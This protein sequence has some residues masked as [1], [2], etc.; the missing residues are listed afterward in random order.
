M[1]ETKK[2]EIPENAQPGD[3]PA[4]N[5][6]R[7]TTRLSKELVKMYPQQKTVFYLPFLTDDDALKTR[8]G[9]GLDAIIRRG[10]LSI[11]HSI[12]SDS[13]FSDPKSWDGDKLTDDAIRRVQIAADSLTVKGR[14]S[15]AG[16][17]KE[18]DIRIDERLKIAKDAGF[19]SIEEFQ[20]ALA[21][22]KKKKNK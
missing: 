19:E 16:K 7:C 17:K 2:V 15:G 10:I 4:E 18:V 22:M 5:W 9:A 21:M 1:E 8:Y 12:D 14:K 20:T 6:V 11:S 3:Y 13:I